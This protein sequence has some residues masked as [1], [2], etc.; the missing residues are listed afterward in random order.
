LSRASDPSRLAVY[1]WRGVEFLAPDGLRITAERIGPKSSYTVFSESGYPRLELIIDRSRTYRVEDVKG[2]VE[3]VLRG[4]SAESWGDVRRDEGEVYGHRA[5]RVT[6]RI[7]D[8]RFISYAWS[9]GGVLNYVKI[10][11]KS[12]EEEWAETLGTMRC[13]RSDGMMLLRLYEFRIL[14]PR[15]LW[16]TSVTSTPGS[17]SMTLE[18]G[19]SAVILER[20]GPIA[21]LGLG[22]REWVKK[23]HAKKL[24]KYTAYPGLEEALTRVGGEHESSVYPIH[25]KGIAVRR[26]V[27]GETE[28]WS[29]SINERFWA[30][31]RISLERRPDPR[32]LPS[33]LIECHAQRL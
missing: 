17:F 25:P 19:A 10:N 13:H 12:G 27:I 7:G 22:L 31:S 4:K 33:I 26:R 9:C 15:T 18:D 5:V 11:L 3:A 8:G 1:G 23:Y 21:A 2:W 24:D 20:A 29:C 30:I 6:G 14:A 32:R 28:A 16:I